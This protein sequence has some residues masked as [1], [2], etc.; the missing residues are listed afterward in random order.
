MNKCEITQL[1]AW[2]ADPVMPIRVSWCNTP[3]DIEYNELGATIFV[4]AVSHCVTP[5]VIPPDGDFSGYNF[6]RR[7]EN[8][9][10]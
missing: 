2:C 9:S 7:N 10:D 4:H 3:M 8:A 6:D 5:P 1:A